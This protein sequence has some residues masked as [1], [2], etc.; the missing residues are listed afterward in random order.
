VGAYSDPESSLFFIDYG[1]LIPNITRY[2]KLFTD[3]LG[4]TGS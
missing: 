2:Q 4:Q 1:E 3:M